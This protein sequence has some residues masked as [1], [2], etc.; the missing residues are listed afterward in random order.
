[1]SNH[2]V[3]GD[4]EE[5]L[6]EAIPPIMLQM[7]N[8]IVRIIL[9]AQIARTSSNSIYRAYQNPNPQ[10]PIASVVDYPTV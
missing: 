6:K 2:V 7:A 5:S 1:V 10:S 4:D 8:I 9:S 3:L